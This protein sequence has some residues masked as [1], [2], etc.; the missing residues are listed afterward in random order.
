MFSRLRLQRL[1][2]S[3]NKLRSMDE[4]AFANL[5]DSLEYLNLENNEL[6]DLPRAVGYLHRL[7][8]LYLGNNALR[9]L[10]NDSF[11]EF[12]SEL[13]AV[14]LA[15]NG[16]ESVPTAALE[17]CSGLLH[18]NLGYNKIFRVNPGDFDWAQNLEILLLRNNILTHL[19][20]NTF[21]GQWLINFLLFFFKDFI[22]I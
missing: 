1:H 20:P 3:S 12:A 5:E 7:A 2:L 10:R 6:T 15:T 13:K 9:S 4:E 19:K 14:S 11:T 21:R 8:Y 18:L 16:F 22:Y 17:D